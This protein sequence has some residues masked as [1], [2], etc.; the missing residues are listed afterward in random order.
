MTSIEQ[1]IAF[2]VDALRYPP[3]PR[4]VARDTRLQTGQVLDS[5]AIGELVLWIEKT[6]GV[7]LLASEIT[8]QRFD[9]VA[10]MAALVE[11]KR[12]TSLPANHSQEATADARP[13]R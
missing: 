6:Y 11:S 8:T 3:E 13:A 7:E 10:Q 12:R 4:P 2:K 1:A 9:T 5:F